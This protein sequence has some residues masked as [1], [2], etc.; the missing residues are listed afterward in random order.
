MDAATG[1]WHKTLPT[2]Q[3]HDKT[4]SA[5]TWDG[6]P[7]GDDPP[8]R[9]CEDLMGPPSPFSRSLLAKST[10]TLQVTS[11]PHHPRPTVLVL[12]VVDCLAAT[13]EERDL[14]SSG[15]AFAG[16]GRAVV[17]CHG[18]IHLVNRSVGMCSTH[19]ATGHHAK[20]PSGEEDE[21]NRCLSHGS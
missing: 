17:F 11:S 3:R 7:N 4:Q 21:Q 8:S 15:W 14:I 6:L 19:T 12:Q 20:S 16:L 1:S 13:I 5:K 18:R 2:T 10:M 9:L